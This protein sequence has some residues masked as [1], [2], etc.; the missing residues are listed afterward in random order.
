MP[1]FSQ[2]EGRNPQFLMCRP[3]KDYMQVSP[4]Y[5]APQSKWDFSGFGGN[6][7]TLQ[8]TPL[9]LFMLM[10]NTTG[11]LGA[12]MRLDPSSSITQRVEKANFCVASVL[13]SVGN[14]TKEGLFFFFLKQTITN[15][16]QQSRYLK[17]K[18]APLKIFRTF[19]LIVVIAIKRARNDMCLLLFNNE[20]KK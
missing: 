12:Y 17:F 2:Y 8:D 1:Q 16:W 11:T 3:N 7:N 19:R 18:L 20:G 4:A 14:R 13:S 15:F 9:W 10:Q 6:E 5:Q